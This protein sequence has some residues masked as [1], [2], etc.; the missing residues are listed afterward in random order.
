MA[1]GH[2]AGP[3]V[4][5]VWTTHARH[6]ERVVLEGQGT[7]HATRLIVQTAYE[8]VSELATL[9]V[10]HGIT[11]DVDVAVL[12]VEGAEL[13]P[14]GTEP[15]AYLA[16]IHVAV[17]AEDG[18]FLRHIIVFSKLRLWECEGRLVYRDGFLPL[19]LIG[20][21]KCASRAA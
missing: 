4:V 21:R 9:S 1:C 3:E 16:C 11:I 12:R 14:R 19:L 20:L 2:A 10:V 13:E 17:G 7:L 8:R 6:A 15:I 18:R 5:V